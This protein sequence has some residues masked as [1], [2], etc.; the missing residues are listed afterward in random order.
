LKPPDDLSLSSIFGHM[1]V[2][3][4]WASTLNP[5]DRRRITAR[6]AETQLGVPASTIRAWASKSKQRLYAVGI[7]P[8][9]RKLYRLSDVLALRDATRRRTYHSRPTR[10]T[11][12]PTE[13]ETR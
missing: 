4:P 2:S 5:P 8:W 10:A 3:E 1:L 7:D 9:G 12:E 11:G 13:L 6:Q